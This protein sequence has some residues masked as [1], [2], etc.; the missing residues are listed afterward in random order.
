[1]LTFLLGITYVDF[2]AVLVIWYGDVPITS[3]WFVMREPWSAL[4]IAAFVLVAL[5]PILALVLTR[6]RRSA[7][8]LRLVGACVLVGLFCY[9]AYLIVP[10]FGALALI[11]ALLATLAIG[12]LFVVL[13]TGI[14]PI[15]ASRARPAY[16]D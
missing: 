13:T 10:L 16:G 4:A 9:D 5:A 12:L 6:A 3:V 15:V 1:L 7:P 11:P 8:G 14:R 2:M